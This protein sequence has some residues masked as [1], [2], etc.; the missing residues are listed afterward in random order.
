MKA[1]QRFLASSNMNGWVRVNG[2][3][4]GTM[5]NVTVISGSYPN[6]HLYCQV[7]TDGP[8]AF[9]SENNTVT[10]VASDTEYS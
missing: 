7:N 3:S 10:V 6:G 1:G 8:V 5:G 4:S 2:G 9:T